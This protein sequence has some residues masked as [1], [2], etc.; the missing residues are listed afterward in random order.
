M[1]IE[2]TA[3]VDL[4]TVLHDIARIKGVGPV[5]EHNIYGAKL[6]EKMLKKYNYP[7]E[8]IEQ[9]KCIYNHI[10][11][12]K[13]SAEEEIVADTDTLTHFDNL[14]TLYYLALVIL[15]LEFGY[16]KL[17]LYGKV[18]YKERYEM[19]IETLFIYNSMS[20]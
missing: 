6:S 7:K 17:S 10:D 20:N 19:I 16:N 4:S 3:D 13:G 18:K 12:P 9:K 2:R 8:K 1:A 14:S 15:R 5:E 11:S